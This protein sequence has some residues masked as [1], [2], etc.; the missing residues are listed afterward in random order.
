MKAVAYKTPGSIDRDDG[1]QDT[2][3]E[4]P[5]AIVL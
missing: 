2:T 4:K 3:L 1:L 5:K